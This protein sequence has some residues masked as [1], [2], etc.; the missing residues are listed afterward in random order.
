[1]DSIY[2]AGI[3]EVVERIR[4]KEISPRE[5]I[6]AHLERIEKLRPKLNA[7]V[8]VDVEGARRKARAAEASVL[9]G[10]ATGALHGVV[11][12]IKSCIDVAGWRCPAGSRLRADYVAG[13]D[14]VL[15]SR[16]RAEGAILIGNTN[17]PEFLMA[18]E[19]N[20]ALCGKTSNPWD[21]SRSAGGS[22]GGEAA[23]IASSCS[24]GGVGSDGGGSVR[25][26]AHYCGI[27][28]L[29]PT[30]GR[31]PSTGHFPRGAGAFAWLG[32]V[33]PMART[34]ADVRVLF[35]VMKGPD[36]NDALS[37]EIEAKSFG[38]RE[39][40]GMRMGILESAALGD[41]TRETSEAVERAAA[42]L[43]E[44]FNVEPFQ[45]RGLEQAIELWWFF[46]G[47]MIA[48]LF[49]PMVEGREAELSPMFREYMSMAK[50]KIAP[51]V[52][53]FM[54]ACVKRDIVRAEIIKQMRDVPIL[55]SPV[56]SAPAFR[57]GE[58]NWHPVSGYRDT[59]RHAQWLNLVGF[60]GVSVPMGFSAEGLPIGV[61]VIGRP[62]EDELVL[63]VAEMLETARG[64][65]EAPPV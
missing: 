19:T 30:P 45:P 20:N 39:L 26:P 25:V 59:M 1:M 5:V 12:S 6:D 65:W 18:Y 54:G 21:L 16:L 63:A 14:A 17:V 32:V 55:L 2:C 35:D 42:L 49:E 33:G 47:P 56:C 11:I 40:A 41:V 23:A 13:E 48:H 29:K 43:S 22:S 4:T 57:H 7:F 64:R 10:D 9:R 27:S 58:G 52:D 60:P 24:M 44:Q 61:Q 62:N 3:A 50:L 31:I 53:E 46:F 8:H 51:T 28:G 34:V 38:E 15:V 37:S 36:G